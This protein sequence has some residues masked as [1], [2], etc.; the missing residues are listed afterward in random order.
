MTF[1]G[2]DV[3]EELDEFAERSGVPKDD[4][5]Y[6]A[7]VQRIMPPARQH[8]GSQ[9]LRTWSHDITVSDKGVDRGATKLKEQVG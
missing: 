6:Q 4:P 7:T 3:L 5:Q 2:W 1:E 8:R 9:G